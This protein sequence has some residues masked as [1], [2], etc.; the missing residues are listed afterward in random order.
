MLS[1][2]MSQSASTCSKASGKA[3]QKLHIR[4]TVSFFER[5]SEGL[6]KGV[7]EEKRKARRQGVK[8]AEG[9]SREQGWVIK[10]KHNSF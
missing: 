9:M 7:R 4:R 6:M 2:T 3:G 10:V 8:E 1:R 5:S